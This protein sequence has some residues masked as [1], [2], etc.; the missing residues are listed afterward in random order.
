MSMFTRWHLLFDHFQ[1]ALIHGPNI[2]GFYALLLS[3]HWT[4]LVP[5]WIDWEQIPHT[6]C[7]ALE[8]QLRSAGVTVRR[9]LTYKGKGE[10]PERW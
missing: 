6:C 1:F 2:P 10:A 9:Y 4:L 5:C 8:Q 3:Q 7:S